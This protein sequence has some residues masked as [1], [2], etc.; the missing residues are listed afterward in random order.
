MPEPERAPL[1]SLPLQ[2]LR[3]V[4]LAHS[5]RWLT[6]DPQRHAGLL[7]RCGDGGSPLAVSCLRAASDPPEVERIGVA[8]R[9]QPGPRDAGPRVLCLTAGRLRIRS[10][11]QVEA[12]GSWRCQAR[13]LPEAATELPAP[14]LL[15][16][17]QALAQAI[18]GLRAR[19]Q[20][21][22]GELRLDDAGW[23]ADRWCELLPIP[24]AARQKLLEL[25]APQQRLRIVDTF[26]REKKIVS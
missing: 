21:L 20:W 17:V 2:P 1:Q 6:L 3:E 10:Q 12:D 14:E 25:D 13:A 19:G 22:H 24:T 16:S 26:L 15:P 23:V 5:R 9:L 18:A 8:A 11:L 7:A 4:L